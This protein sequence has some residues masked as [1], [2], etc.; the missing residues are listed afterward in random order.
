VGSIAVQRKVHL[1]P[2]D[3]KQLMQTMKAFRFSL[4]AEQSDA[5]AF[6][7]GIIEKPWGHEYRVYSDHF[8]DIW[9]LCI[10][11][12]RM[13]SFHCH[14]RKESALLCLDG[15][16]H[17]QCL[18][19]AYVV[20]PGEFFL[21][22]KG[23]FHRTENIGETAL[24]L[25]EVELPRNKFDLVRGTDA[26][27]RSA[28]HY[29]QRSL[30]EKVVCPLRQSELVADAMIRDK[31]RE[32]SYR[33]TLSRGTELMLPRENVLFVVSLSLAHALEQS[34]QLASRA[35]RSQRMAIEPEG[36]YLVI[37]R[38]RSMSV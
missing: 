32:D 35:T 38:N 34:I 10:E 31:D 37:Q 7:N 9:K 33:F 6:L 4:K 15:I 16:A 26:Y 17:F 29:E 11:P 13:T 20:R 23:V 30:E 19:H 18:E 2:S 1:S 12:G 24:H 8:Y 21:I 14:P 27:G 28:S 3:A 5:D 22:E 25:V 36:L